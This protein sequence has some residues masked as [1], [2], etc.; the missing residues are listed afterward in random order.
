[1]TMTMTPKGFILL[2]VVDQAG[3]EF[4]VLFPVNKIAICSEAVGDAHPLAKATVVLDIRN[5][6]PAHVKE[7]LDQI[8]L[9]IN[10]AR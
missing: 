1:M 8:A 3:D 9:L 6:I 7:P 5:A 2:T 10:K 4:A